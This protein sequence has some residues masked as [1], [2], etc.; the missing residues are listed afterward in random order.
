MRRAVPL[1]ALGVACAAPPQAAPEAP[2]A[3]PP[4]TAA[5]RPPVAAAPSPPPAP[6]AIPGEG[7]R[8]L[9]V[10]PGVTVEVAAGWRAESQPDLLVLHDPE[11]VLTVASARVA[12]ATGEAA[13]RA[14]WARVDPEMR[15]PEAEVRRPPATDG[16]DEVARV[17]YAVPPDPPRAVLAVARRFRDHWYVY[18]VE[19][20]EDALERRGAQAATVFT[21]LKVPGR[22]GE[23]FGRPQRLTKAK[24]L[25]L[26]RFVESARV[27]LEVPGV[28]LA[29]VSP[30]G[31]I[32]ARGFGIE[33][34]GGAP[35]TPRTRFLIG[36]VTKPLTTLLEARL[37]ARGALRWDTRVQDI[38]PEFALADPALASQLLLRHTACACTGLPRRDLQFALAWRSATPEGRVAEMKTWVPT[39][40]LGETFQYSNHLVAVGG[41]M[42][43]RARSPGEPLGPAYDAAMQAEVFGPLGMRDSTLDPTAKG[44]R[45]L[46][47]GQR[48]DGPPRPIPLDDE[49]GVLAVRPAGGVWSTAQDLARYL[50]M[51]LGEGA[52][53]G[54]RYIAQD[55]LLARRRPGIRI[56]DRVSYGLGLF[57]EEVGGVLRVGHGGNNMGFTADLWFLPDAGIGVALLMNA[58]DADDLSEAVRRRVLELFFDAAPQAEAR[59]AYRVEALK[60]AKAQEAARLTP[61]DPALGAA[62]AG[63]Y[64]E[65]S[66]GEVELRWSEGVSSAD[67]GEYRGTLRARAEDGVGTVLVAVDPPLVGLTLV[68]VARAGGWDLRISAEQD[69]FE[70]VRAP[71]P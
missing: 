52:L 37:V 4:S 7:P 58:Q 68:P 8:T 59:L 21:S 3:G 28:A 36:S 53:D 32:M 24:Q 35:I 45:A 43:G 70:L 42:A 9:E 67:F 46:P 66:L 22:S 55:A 14:T 11:G 29:V 64:T 50:R 1:L 69:T 51:E 41:F 15:W 12:A 38:L 61:V 57:V 6:G 49:G 25:A 5:P 23:R 39:T 44:P 40:G 71:P 17:E 20:P 27:A 56:T 60:K 47:H 34:P 31:V 10:A 13:V 62:L 65:P 19:G 2:P 33:G 16:W 54:S 63:R 48:L 30:G 26:A 18:L